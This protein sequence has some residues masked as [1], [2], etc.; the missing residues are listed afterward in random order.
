ML[1]ID[2]NVTFTLDSNCDVIIVGC[3]DTV[4]FASATVTIDF[5]LIAK[6]LC[7]SE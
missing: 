5:I 3:A 4:G 7:E 2:P 1:K 6:D